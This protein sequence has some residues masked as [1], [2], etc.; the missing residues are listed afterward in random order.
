ME[1]LAANMGTIVVGLILAV[2][3]IW[4]IRKIISDRKKGIK[5]C[6]MNCA[7][8]TGS[9]T[10]GGCC[11][12]GESTLPDEK[13]LSGPKIGEK[14]VH[15]EGMHCENCKNRVERAINRID[16]A[17]AKVNLKK[18]IAVVSF[19]RNI[20]EEEIKRAVEEQD[21]KVVMIE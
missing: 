16:G 15:I 7:G 17:V 6:G 10:N 11:G 13:E 5:S 3:V 8:C 2:I 19:D 4:D 20:S 12:G 21:F 14:T 18:N 9:C 1:W